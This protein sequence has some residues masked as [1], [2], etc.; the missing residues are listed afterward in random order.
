MQ[1]NVSPVL[2]AQQ[3][4][5]KIVGNTDVLIQTVGSIKIQQR[6]AILWA[7]DNDNLKKVN[8]GYVIVSSFLEIPDFNF[9]VTYLI[10]EEKPRLVFAKIINEFFAHELQEDFTNHVDYHRQ[11]QNLKIGDNVFI[12]SDVEIGDGT[13]L[14][15]NVVIYSKTKIG[16]NCILR[17]HVSLGTEG[18]GLELDPETNKFIK[19]PQMGGVILEDNVEI[20]PTSTV[21]RSALDNTLIKQGTKIGSLVNI[22]HNCVIGENCILTCQIVTSGS[23]IIGDNVF[24]GVNSTVKNG[25]NIG[26]NVTIGQGAVVTRNVA[27]NFTF[28]GNPAENILDYRAWSRMK[29]YLMNFFWKDLQNI[30]EK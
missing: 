20:G 24:M 1:A 3:F 4:N 2:I 17:T 16:K 6:D 28:V 22:G 12:G 14:H 9:N 5:L 13:I 25:I 26:N 18:L 29:K 30:N 21:R 8:F 15:P 27:D 7:K 19:F 11:N 10:T 23:S